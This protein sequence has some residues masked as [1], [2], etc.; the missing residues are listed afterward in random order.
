MSVIG[1]SR[2]LQSISYGWGEPLFGDEVFPPRLTHNEF[3]IVNPDFWDHGVDQD[4]FS[5]WM[6]MTKVSFSL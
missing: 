3:T 2:C 6:H 1:G 5:G 4:K